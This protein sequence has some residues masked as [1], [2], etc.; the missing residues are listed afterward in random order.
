MMI[1]GISNFPGISF[2]P[3]SPF[4]FLIGP[5]YWLDRHLFHTGYN[6]STHEAFPQDN[7]FGV[8]FYLSLVLL[9]V[10]GTLVWSLLDRKRQQYDR[11]LFWFRVYLRY[12]LA[13]IMFEYG[14][15]KFIPVQMFY[16]SVVD[17]LTPLGEQTRFKILWNFMGVSPGYMV[18]TG[19]SEMAGS[20]L[21]LNRR[22]VVLGYLLLVGVLTNVVAFNL[23]Y[24]VPV[25]MFSVQLLI[26]TLFL[27]AP[28]VS[29]LFRLF[30]GGQAVALAE[31]VYRFFSKRKRYQLFG[32]LT[33]VPLIFFFLVTVGTF[34][35][36]KR[37]QDMTRHEKLYDVNSFVAGPLLKDTLPPLLT[38]AFRWKRLA[39]AY[40]KYAVIFDMKDKKDFYE[41]D[42]D[43]SR[44][45][46]KLHDGSDSG[47]FHYTY[48][49]GDQLQLLGKWK[50][51]D[52]KV[53]LQPVSIDSMAV[54]KERAKWVL[55]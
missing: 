46:F 47:V 21:L 25:K 24:N 8:V 40:S 42:A 1:F 7:H 3:A 52:I 38:D 50:G 34:I 14:V 36:Y 49:P 45:T 11:L 39:F 22:S 2:N 55:D 41:C 16:P 9:A 29:R 51:R 53:L 5:F 33:A 44:Q 17:L 12:V 35:R 23:L 54:N 32:V 13:M 26:Y 31:P 20:L 4:K 15:I 37:Q 28:Y 48:S 19:L 43:S 18:L 6:P 27:V 30:F 10:I